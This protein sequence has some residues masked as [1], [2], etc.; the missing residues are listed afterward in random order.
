M[1]TQQK[2]VDTAR[3][4]IQTKGYNGFSYAD[5]A[6][7]VQLRKASI[8]H[9]FPA[10]S[11][12]A[13]AVVE[14]S[15]GVIEEQARRLTS[16]D[17]DPQQQLLFYTGYWEKCIADATAP[18]CVAGMLAAEM[19]TLPDDLAQAVQEHFRTLSYWLETVL[20]KGS[21]LGVFRLRHSVRREA[22]AFMSTVYGAMLIARA[23]ASPR[24]FPEI[25][26]LALKQLLG[27]SQGHHDDASR[28]S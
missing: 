2:L 9:Y 10:K 17:F 11:D 5:V 3:Y 22:E 20:T 18:F 27:T 8:H 26:E 23:Y 7:Q 14:Q 4:L 21:Q 16:E 15:R 1:S 6:E 28:A 24:T 19:P 13:R 12:L 25:V